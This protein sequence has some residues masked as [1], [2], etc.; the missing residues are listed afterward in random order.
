MNTQNSPLP[1]V[2]WYST[3]T[4]GYSDSE[5]RIWLRFTSTES[6]AFAWI[7]RRLLGLTINKSYEALQGLIPKPVAKIEHQAVVSEF[8]KTKGHPAP[9]KPEKP[10]ETK[11]IGLINSVILRKNSE[12]FTW[13]FKHGEQE[14]GITCN[15]S[16]AHQI[17]EAMW[18]R[19]NDAGWGIVA[20]WGSD[21]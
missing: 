4:V 18:I 20:P 16:Y 1:S 11:N 14:I 5:D 21:Q 8:K 12:S 3:I 6:E 19:Q 10:I 17:L 2:T 9:A 7:S 15:K 13:I